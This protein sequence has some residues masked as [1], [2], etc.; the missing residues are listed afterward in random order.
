M[1]VCAGW[2]L[3]QKLPKD[4]DEISPDLLSFG[5]F[6]RGYGEY[7]ADFSLGGLGNPVGQHPNSNDKKTRSYARGQS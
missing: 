7:Y 2:V 3:L 6:V 1:E 4:V 5:L